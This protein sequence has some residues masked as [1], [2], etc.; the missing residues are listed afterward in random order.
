MTGCD[1]LAN[2]GRRL[3]DNGLLAATVVKPATARQGIDMIGR[4]LRRESC[5]P[6]VLVSPQPY[7][8]LEQLAKTR[9]GK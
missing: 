1:G 7:P 2:S 4:W 3:V 8:A 5:P 9:M 6:R